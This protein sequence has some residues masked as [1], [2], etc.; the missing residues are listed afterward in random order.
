[1]I[2][3]VTSCS[4]LGSKHLLSR[5]IGHIHNLLSDLCSR[6]VGQW[7]IIGHVT[8]LLLS[9]WSMVNGHAT[10][11]PFLLVSTGLPGHLIGHVNDLLLPHW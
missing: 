2:I 6:L 5:L 7:P 9:D 4:L 8:N 11:L 1:M 10:K 3:L